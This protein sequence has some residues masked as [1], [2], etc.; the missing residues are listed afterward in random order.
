[1][2]FR[3]TLKAYVHSAAPKSDAQMN[4]NINNNL[5]NVVDT[6]AYIVALKDNNGDAVAASRKAYRKMRLDRVIAFM[7]GGEFFDMSEINDI[8]EE[9]KDQITKNMA[10][11]KSALQTDI[12]NTPEDLPVLPEEEQ[13]FDEIFESIR[14]MKK[15]IEF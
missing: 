8:P 6:N 2:A 3:K 14:K 5:L 12:S 9:L 11:V 7:T 13:S 4:V 10:K 1:M 15:L